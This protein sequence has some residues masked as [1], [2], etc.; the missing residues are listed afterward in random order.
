MKRT[1]SILLLAAMLLSLL[2]ACGEGTDSGTSAKTAPVQS[3]AGTEAETEP[4]L[5]LYVNSSKSDAAA[6]GLDG[7]KMNVYFRLPGT[8]CNKDIYSEEMTGDLLNDTTY[9][10]NAMLQ[11]RFGFTIGQTLS[12]TTQLKEL[13][14]LV[15]AGDDSVDF[16]LPMAS[17]SATYAQE[18]S[19]I[20]LKSVQYLDLTSSPWDNIFNQ[21]LEL[22][23]HLFM[24][25]GLI[26][27][28]SLQSI[29]VYYFSKEILAD[30]KLEDPYTLVR[31]GKWTID[32]LDEMAVK[33][34]KDANGDGVMDVT[35][36]L[37]GMAWQSAMSGFI[38]YMGTGEG[39]AGRG[40]DGTPTYVLTGE[41]ALTAFER[42]QKLVSNSKV[43]TLGGDTEMQTCF[44]ERHALFTTEVLNVAEKLRD[45][46]ND[47][48]ILPCPKLDETQETYIQYVDS[49]CPSPAVIPKTVKNVDR[50]GFVLQVLAETGEEFIR[51][52]FYDKCLT[53]K[54]LRDQES[55]E[56][57]D[58]IA[59]TY[60][61]DL[62]VIYA[63]GGVYSSFKSLF[64]TTNPLASFAAS[65]KTPFESAVADTMKKLAENAG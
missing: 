19:I 5:R 41:R 53:A 64:T 10:R 16:A 11:D 44:A 13:T 7:Y 58:I 12:A 57:L 60:K 20:D 3:G 47:F 4:D 17:Q 29:R 52:V 24:A 50:V 32:K 62:G 54:S 40:A 2:S 18:G 34:A 15:Q 43:Y 14:A 36:D 25:N 37:W 26:S 8:W 6:L 56:M 28:N 45:S 48:G 46:D 33:V 61:L 9:T 21:S 31:E 49:W 27:V 30:N 55:S 22:G 51:P 35:N 39:I 63:W 1:F 59:K 65:N 42:V 23:G 38:L